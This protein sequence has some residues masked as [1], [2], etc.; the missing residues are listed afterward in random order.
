MSHGAT[1]PNCTSEVGCN[2][3]EEGDIITCGNCGYQFENE[4]TI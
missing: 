3:R 1:C 2:V 4:E